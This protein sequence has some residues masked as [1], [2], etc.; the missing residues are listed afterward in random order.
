[1]KKIA[2]ALLVI[3]CIALSPI[4]IS[5]SVKAD[6]GIKLPYTTTS[7]WTVI[8]V[9]FI[10]VGYMDDGEGYYGDG[11]YHYSIGYIELEKN[12]IRFKGT[13][14]LQAMVW[15]NG[16]VE[17]G[18]DGKCYCSSG[19]QDGLGHLAPYRFPVD[20]SLKELTITE[21]KTYDD[22]RIEL[23]MRL[24]TYPIMMS[25][26]YID[27]EWVFIN[28]GTLNKIQD[29][30]CT[31][32]VKPEILC[33]PEDKVPDRKQC[34]LPTS[35]FNPTN[36]N[37]T[38]VGSGVKSS[39][40]KFG[41]FA[42]TIYAS[43]GD[44][45]TYQNC[46]YS[47]VQNWHKTV[48]QNLGELRP[49][50]WGNSFS[51][52]SYS[53]GSV[54]TRKQDKNTT[55]T[56]SHVGRTLT[57]TN[58]SSSPTDCDIGCNC[59]G[60]STSKASVVIPYN[61]KNSIDDIKPTSGGVYAGESIN[62][63]VTYNIG[64]KYNRLLEKTYATKIGGSGA[65]L[66]IETIIDGQTT[67]VKE[68]KNISAPG[69]RSVSAPIEIPDKPAG[70]EIKVRAWMTPVDS[71]ADDNTDPNKFNWGITEKTI[72]LKIAKKPTLQ[73]WGAGMFTN[74]RIG[75]PVSRKLRVTGINEGNKLSNPV[76]FSSWVEQNI[77]ANGSLS[78]LASGAATGNYTSGSSDTPY[79]G[80]GGSVVADAC[81][82]SP[83]TMPSSAC[84]LVS[85]TPKTMEV[86]K[87]REGLISTL[88]DSYGDKV[89]I[90]DACEISEIPTSTTKNT[91][92]YRCNGTFTV[93]GDVKYAGPWTSILSIPK[94]LVYATGGI[95]INCAVTRIDAVLIAGGLLNTCADGGD[96]N[97]KARSNQLQI[98]GVVVADKMAANRTY[99][100][101]TGLNS[102]VPAEVINYDTSLYLWG[103]GLSHSLDSGK[104]EATY[105]VELAPRY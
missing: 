44:Q 25:H 72:T 38:Y 56:S 57:E 58:T 21:V 22:G 74:G 7:G 45:V 47:G 62:V 49:K 66:H 98:N 5:S 78:G 13:S 36:S 14:E 17:E 35:L 28:D 95:N 46:Y 23:S 67:A 79:N 103:A 24:R 105:Q 50:N 39:N 63:N 85:F 68:Y 8:A 55:I 77:V 94:V 53:L 52:G 26:Y 60:T 80:L 19:H 90:H 75:L 100:A 83:L 65:S 89:E 10:D 69:Q 20:E 34:G 96:V 97:S 37:R 2:S 73:V 12:G 18:V 16:W 59:S 82:R 104:L 48:L 43:P 91:H 84:N 92:V 6:E 27:G 29:S 88:L 40:T 9:R 102:T 42:S 51:G 76:Y 101:S 70:A 81:L 3:F 31:I 87:T 32:I 93:R 1:M 11:R 54:T 4:V 99:G 30:N 15:R 41:N 61:F 64:E 86:P 71:G 33:T